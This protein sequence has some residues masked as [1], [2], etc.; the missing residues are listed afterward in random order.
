M[1]NIFLNRETLYPIVQPQ[2]KVKKE[3]IKKEKE[4]FEH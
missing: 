3:I 2:K 4:V 1:T